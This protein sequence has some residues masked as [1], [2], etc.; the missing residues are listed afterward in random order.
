MH[1][2]SADCNCVFRREL[3]HVFAR[4][5]VEC[6]CGWKW[7]ASPLPTCPSP[8]ALLFWRWLRNMRTSIALAGHCWFG[9]HDTT[10][11]R[12]LTEIDASVRHI[13]QAG[14]FET[15]MKSLL[16]SQRH[17]Q[18]EC[19]VD[20]KGTASIRST[21]WLRQTGHIDIIV[22]LSFVDLLGWCA[23]GQA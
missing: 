1:A 21:H 4:P 18:K 16:N 12:D 17:R 10:C 23:R 5:W 8:V 7:C 15:T 13:D 11:M 9:T 19:H 20:P 14:N 2:H 3:H 6:W 22:V